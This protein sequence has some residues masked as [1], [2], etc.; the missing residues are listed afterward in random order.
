VLDGLPARTPEDDYNLACYHAS[1][2]GLADRPGPGITAAEGRHE[3]ERAM[4]ELRRAA[5]GG[6]RMLSLMATDHDLDPLRSRPDFRMLMMDLTF[7][8]EPFAR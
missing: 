3:A 7:P 5:G 4:D 1:L 6:F 2:A 8:D